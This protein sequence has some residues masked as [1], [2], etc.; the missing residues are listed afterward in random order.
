M[1]E[2]YLYDKHRKLAIHWLDTRKKPSEIA[3]GH[4]VKNTFTTAVDM[5]SCR[6]CWR[7]AHP[8]PSHFKEKTDD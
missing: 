6:D 7:L 5:V 1:S 3:C 8:E 2:H 4:P